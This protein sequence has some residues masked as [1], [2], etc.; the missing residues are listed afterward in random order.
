[1]K[2]ADLRLIRKRLGITQ[3][4]FADR[5]GVHAVTV[6]K[7]EAGM[8]TIRNTH[9]TLIRLIAAQAQGRRKR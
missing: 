8:Q 5:L 1:M 6:R 3:E 7:W 2:P 4:Q 9:A